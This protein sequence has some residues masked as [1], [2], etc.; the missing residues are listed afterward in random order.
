MSQCPFDNFSNMVDPD[1]Y[2]KGMPYDELARVRKSGPVHYEV[3]IRMAEEENNLMPPGAFLPFVEKYKMMPRIDRWVVEYMAGW[4]EKHQTKPE[5][6]FCI[7]VA[8]DTLSDADFP[9][10]VQEQIQAAK[11][12]KYRPPPPQK[13]EMP[14][15][16][17]ED[18]FYSNSEE[19][20]PLTDY[21]ESYIP[22][23]PYDA[24]G[25]S[26]AYY[27]QQ[28]KPAPMPQLSSRSSSRVTE[29][30]CLSMLLIDPS[31]LAHVNRKLRELAGDNQGLLNGPLGDFSTEDFSQ[32]DYRILLDALQSALRQNDAEP[33]DYLQN[34][35]DDS[36]LGELST[37]LLDEQQD[38]HRTVRKRLGGEFE[39]IW[40]KFARNIRPGINT[41]TDVIQRALQV[42]HQRLQR[43][44]EEIRFLL[45]D[46]MRENDVIAEKTYFEQTVPTMKALRLLQVELQ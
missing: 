36:L 44:K 45:E 29:A 28:A 17:D 21:D 43:E 24:E 13:L 42:R 20:P 3:L 6:I 2:A 1:T 5:S 14:P 30:Y 12:P 22:E 7:N 33:L 16:R 46:A 38:I 32:G 35:L 25:Q 34:M 15:L 10:F 39:Q 41:Q 19:P 9:Q 27:E 18:E 23:D 37:L 4:L 31:T 40:D 11:K 8:R 26:E